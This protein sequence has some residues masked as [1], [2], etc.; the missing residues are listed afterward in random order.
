[1]DTDIYGDGNDDTNYVK[2]V[3]PDDEN[4]GDEDAQDFEASDFSDR[5]KRL[6]SGNRF[7][8]ELAL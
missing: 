2:Y 3:V 4:S 1:M 5:I 6:E 8:E 7:K